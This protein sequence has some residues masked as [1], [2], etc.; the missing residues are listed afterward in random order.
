[1]ALIESKVAEFRQRFTNLIIQRRFGTTQEDVQ[2]LFSRYA[3]AE[4]NNFLNKIS[5]KKTDSE[6]STNLI[7]SLVIER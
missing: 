6:M 5:V 2:E 3:N 7:R 1:M 4:P